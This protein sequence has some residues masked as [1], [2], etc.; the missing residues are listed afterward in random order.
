MDLKQKCDE[1]LRD[2]RTNPETRRKIKKDG[3]IHR[4]LTSECKSFF[5][6]PPVSYTVSEKDIINQYCMGADKTT[7]QEVKELMKRTFN[8][9]AEKHLLERPSYDP[10]GTRFCHEFVPAVTGLECVSSDRHIVVLDFM[11]ASSTPLTQD[12]NFCDVSYTGKIKYAIDYIPVAYGQES[13][14]LSSFADI[15]NSSCNVLLIHLDARIGESEDKDDRVLI[16]NFIK[17]INSYL[18]GYQIPKVVY[19]FTNTRKLSPLDFSPEINE[20]RVLNVIPRTM[21][22]T[23]E[24]R[25]GVE[26]IPQADY[27]DS[28]EKPSNRLT[29]Q[30]WFRRFFSTVFECGKGR[31]QQL[32]GTC[33][34]TAVFNAIILGEYTKR[35]V[36]SAINAYSTAF[37][38]EDIE[39]IKNP[40]EYGVCVDITSVK[41]VRTRLKY[42]AKI[43]YNTI[44]QT[45][46]LPRINPTYKD[47]FKDLGHNYFRTGEEV[48]EGGASPNVLFK[49]LLDMRVNFL[50]GNK[51]GKLYD[52]YRSRPRQ[53]DELYELLRGIPT[54][55]YQNWRKGR[56][57]FD[58]FLDVGE[59]VNILNEV[60]KEDLSFVDADI[61]L[62]ITDGIEPRPLPVFPNFVPETSCIYIFFNDKD[63]NIV[64]HNV[65]GFICDG[66]YKIFDSTGV[67]PISNCLWTDPVQL[68]ETYLDITR[69]EYG[70]KVIS[71]PCINSA[72][73]VNNGK[74][75]RERYREEG[76][77]RF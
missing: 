64:G 17:T 50:V 47:V 48:I 73:Y 2:Q 9:V 1:F 58:A 75:R 41:D 76:V 42:Y 55:A 46:S 66:N 62:Y 10:F 34:M 35:I 68:A 52:P 21:D 63:G 60:D 15:L 4:R 56:N 18:T 13:L 30:W 36:I 7:K 72:I 57:V 3:P 74:R 29:C 67:R 20:L 45:K 8:S 49:M 26:I 69:P 61:I 31:L 43:M 53:V 23:R 16:L 12:Y 25:D 38:Q 44:C 33:Y 5:K 6:L 51:D 70:L 22:M 28:P 37:S 65:C 14:D 54:D 11:T 40:I 39:S 59:I 77:C 24:V 71:K 32:S 27:Y 19:S